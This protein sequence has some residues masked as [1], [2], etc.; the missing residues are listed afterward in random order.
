MFYYAFPNCDTIYQRRDNLNRHINRNHS[1]QQYRYKCDMC[2]SKFNIIK[3]YIKH[4][5]KQHKPKANDGFNQTLHF[6][7]ILI[8]KKMNLQTS[9]IRQSMEKAL[10]HIL[11]EINYF[12]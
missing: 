4:V 7:N 12:V 5:I 6:S 8:E 10:P 3:N 2:K 9:S 1:E 11:K